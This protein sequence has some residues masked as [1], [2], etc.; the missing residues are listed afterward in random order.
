MSACNLNSEVE[1]QVNLEENPETGL[2]NIEDAADTMIQEE[3]RMMDATPSPEATMMPEGQTM[4]NDGA[5]V[6][7]EGDVDVE[8]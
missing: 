1:P 3:T 6:R 5:S 7:L 2:E 8:R 4:E